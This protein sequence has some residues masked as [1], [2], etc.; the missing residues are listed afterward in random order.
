MALDKTAIATVALWLVV[1]AMHVLS[2]AFNSVVAYVYHTLPSTVLSADLVV[3]ELTIDMSVFPVVVA[4]HGLC[5]AAH[6]AYFLEMLVQSL[7]HRVWYFHRHTRKHASRTAP[8]PPSTSSTIAEANEHRGPTPTT[9][10]LPAT[11]DSSSRT[12]S[13]AAQSLQSKTS[14][15]WERSFG[16]AGFFGVTSKH[17]TLLFLAREVV[18]TVLQSIQALRLSYFVPRVWLNHLAVY[19]V[20]ANCWSTPTI[21]RLVASKPRLELILCL[22]FDAVLDFISGVGVPTALGVT[23]WLDYDPVITNFPVATWFNLTWYAYMM[24]EL[25]LVFVQSWYDLGSRAF[26]ALTLLLS[27]DDVKFLAADPTIVLVHHKHKKS[28]SKQARWHRGFEK[29]VHTLF[30]AWGCLIVGLHIEAAKDTVGVECV[31]Q[32]R[33]WL[34]SQPACAF[35]RANC[36]SVT[37]MVGTAAQLESVWSKYDPNFVSILSISNCAE[38]HMPPSIQ[39]FSNMGGLY[40]TN[41]V[42]AE[43][44]E[45]AALTKQRHHH[46]HHFAAVALD[47]SMFANTSS[48]LP[49]GLVT[50]DFPPTLRLVVISSCKLRELP[51]DLDESWPAGASIVIAD[52][53]FTEVP[54]VVL[55]MKAIKVIL[56]NNPIAELPATLFEIPTLNWLE[57]AQLPITALPAD[58]TPSASLHGIAFQ[59]SNVTALPSWMLADGFADRVN[60]R[61][62]GSP[63]CTHLQ[64]DQD[65]KSAKLA[66][67][68]CLL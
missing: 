15:A 7:R 35:V 18:E 17:F 49:P 62:G 13:V 26:F 42:L 2:S 50:R 4:F 52:N 63:Y 51:A 10:Q 48:I 3:F 44:S 31:V 61:G 25:Q 64:Q 34:T 30:I 38:V 21:Q 65:A 36:L 12:W 20:A 24:N 58:A 8:A 22:L 60:V 5:A 32:M 27:L 6:L 39:A 28:E 9:D 43:W 57:I 66:A 11:K 40:I 45:A 41:S 33:P 67:T 1:L 53:M 59:K 14:S 29:T 55:R 46:L 56:S 23:Y 16:Y 68:Y 37:G 47:L 54:A 19:A